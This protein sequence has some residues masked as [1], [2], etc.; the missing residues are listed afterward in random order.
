MVESLKCKTYD[1]AVDGGY[2]SGKICPF[3]ATCTGA[4]CL[5]IE[6]RVYLDPSQFGAVEP[7]DIAQTDRLIFYEHQ[8]TTRRNN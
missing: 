4:P 6:A 1:K 5:N 3:A 7:S 8:K 2:A